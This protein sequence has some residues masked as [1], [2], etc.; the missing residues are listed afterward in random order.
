MNTGVLCTLVYFLE[1]RSPS[2]KQRNKQN[3]PYFSETD[4]LEGRELPQQGKCLPRK[5]DDLDLDQQFP[6]EM[7][8]M[9]LLPVTP[10]LRG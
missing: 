4:K 3:N 7:L 8:G 6:F 5:H 2:S 1:G 10:L 9:W